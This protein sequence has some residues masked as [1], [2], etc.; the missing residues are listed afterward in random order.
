MGPTDVS[1]F[2]DEIPTGLSTPRV[3][4]PRSGKVDA[5]YGI[6]R[7]RCGDNPQ[8]SLVA[9]CRG[10]V[11]GPLSPRSIVYPRAA[12]RRVGGVDASGG[13]RLLRSGIGWCAATVESETSAQSVPES[14]SHAQG[15]NAD[16]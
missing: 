16:Y 11:S 8:G 5:G 15:P 6:Q 14:V 3:H 7:G 4:R 9:G 13:A 2:F 12:L 10:R 1:K